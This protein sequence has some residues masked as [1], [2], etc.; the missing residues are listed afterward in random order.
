FMLGADF[1]RGLDQLRAFSL[2]FDLL[3]FPR[4]LPAAREVVARFPEQPFVL[5]HLAKPAIKQGKLEPWATEIRALARH[6][7]V[8]CKL[9]GLV[10]EADHQNW[11][12]DDLHPYL[13]IAAEAFGLE[14]L[15]IGSDWP[16][17]LLAASYER[18]L[19]TVMTWAQ[20]FS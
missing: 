14:R 20:K 6:P 10:T 15:M 3:I 4:Q 12:E 13:D 5:D 1:L 7:N 18:T 11:R 19:K 2:T 9:S 16:V 8:S 17:C